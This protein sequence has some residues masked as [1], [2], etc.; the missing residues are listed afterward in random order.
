MS[1]LDTKF[2]LNKKGDITDQISKYQPTDEEVAQANFGKFKRGQS[3]DFTTPL[4]ADPSTAL[5]IPAPIFC[6]A[7][8]FCISLFLN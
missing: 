4:N 8:F 3:E 2:S 5:T 1:M 7:V 6:P